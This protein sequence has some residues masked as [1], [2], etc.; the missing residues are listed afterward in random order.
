M[1]VIL[2][3]EQVSLS[4]LLTLVTAS[5]AA[6]LIGTYLSIFLYGLNI[7]QAY[8]YL[9]AFSTDSLYIR[10]LVICVLVLE[11]VH[12]VAT[13]D[14][15]YHYLIVNYA[16]PVSLVRGRW[17][18]MT[19][20]VWTGLVAF[21]SQLFF[22]RRVSLI[23]SR[24]RIVIAVVAFGLLAELG[25]TFFAVAAIYLP[26]FSAQ[27]AATLSAAAFGMAGIADAA[28][29]VTLLFSVWQSRR[30]HARTQS[31]SWIDVL[32]LYVLNT[33]VATSL[34][35]LLAFIT[36]LALS[37]PQ[38]LVFSSLGCITT[39]LYGNTL[40]AVLN[41]RQQRG[42]EFVVDGERKMSIVEA[43]IAAKLDLWNAPQLPQATAPRKISIQI[44][45]E[46]EG[47]RYI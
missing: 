36:G 28:L 5:Y 35:N 34:F 39:R 30:G 8:R 21:V 19:L 12:F 27:S 7:H 2:V 46:S 24:F 4:A 38:T 15:C 26:S 45:Q 6:F 18:L 31:E 13:I 40:L 16:N 32:Q 14:I 42:M 25:L 20:P 44:M 23:T 11:T 3:E 33:G 43:H 22:V 1:P 47:S 29:T 41:S 17:S 37:G 9:R 10:W